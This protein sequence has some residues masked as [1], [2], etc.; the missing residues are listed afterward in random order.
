MKKALIWVCL[1][2]SIVL[3]GSTETQARDLKPI[4]FMYQTSAFGAP[5]FVALEKGWYEQALNK[6]GYTLKTS[7][8]LFGPP[9]VEAMAAGQVDIGELGVAPHVVAVAR[10][11][12]IKAVVTTNIAG[13]SIMVPRDS[14]V[15]E[16]KQLMGK[17]IS[18]PG[19]GTMQDFI[20][21]RALVGAGL[22][23]DADVKW[24]ELSPADMSVMLERKQIDAAVLWEPWTARL[25]LQ[26][27][28]V[29]AS[30]Q[31]VWPD[32]DNQLISVTEAAIRDDEPAVRVFVEQT[33]RG[34]AYIMDNPDESITIT[35]RHLGL[36]REVIAKSWPMM[37][38][39]RSGVP[40]AASLQ[41]FADA[42]YK[43]GYIKRK[44]NSR[45]MI[46]TRFLKQ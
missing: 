8:A 19:K 1:V 10:G 18:I 11:L 23:P 27:Q 30:G 34:L 38:R 32:H 21:R 6:I 16:L 46:D 42:L 9:I 14:P 29:L 13:E 25:A 12:P 28:R 7:T 40:N 20:I 2:V 41:E 4:R 36:E 39:R 5:I 35:A 15:K 33:L 45:D 3:I 37:I 31:D 26:G 17:K 44:I 43:W 24:V 22:N